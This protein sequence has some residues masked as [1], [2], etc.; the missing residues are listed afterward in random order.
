MNELNNW[1]IEIFIGA[2]SSAAVAITL[3]LLISYFILSLR[4]WI[5]R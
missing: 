4:K 1:L 5:D 3:L 2:F